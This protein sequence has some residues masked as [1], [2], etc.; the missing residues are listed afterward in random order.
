MSAS[1]NKGNPPESRITARALI[2]G[3]VVAIVFAAVT[4]Y[5]ENRKYL[6]ITATQIAVL[7]YMFLILTVLLINPLCRLLRI[8]RQFTMTEFLIIFIMGSVSAGI[9]T[10]G[11]ASQLMPATG[12]LFNRNWNNDQTEWNRYIEPVVNEAYFLSVPGIQDAAKAYNG[13]LEKFK[14]AQ[15]IYEA[16]L[17][18]KRADEAVDAARKEAEAADAAT[19]GTESERE[20]QRIRARDILNAARAVQGGARKTWEEMGKIDP[21]LPSRDE[22]LSAYPALI[23]ERDAA[24]KAKKE[25]LRVLEDAAAEKVDLFRRG[26]PE[27]KRAYPGF[28]PIVGD[29]WKTYWSRFQ[30][31]VHGRAAYRTLRGACEDLAAVMTP[32]AVP[33]D[34]TARVDE[35]IRLA[36]ERLKKVDMTADLEK[37]KKKLDDAWEAQKNDLLKV[38]AAVKDMN[39]KRRQAAAEDFDRLDKEIQKLRNKERGLKGRIEAF[40][41]R[42]EQVHFEIRAVSQVT[43][44]IEGLG[45]TAARLKDPNAD[46]ASLREGIGK[47]MAGFPA[48]DASLRRYLVSDVPWQHWARLML[49][50]GFLIVLTYVVLMAFNVLIF[51]QWAK[52]EKLIY[53]LAELPEMLAG[54][55]SAESGRMP[56]LFRTGFFWAGF[57]IAGATLGWN[58]LCYSKVIPGLQPFD[59][60]NEWDPY[61][62]NGPL[63][64]LY[65]TAKSHIFFTMI[66]LAFLVP[67]KISFSLWFFSILYMVQL[68]IIVWTGYGVNEES[69]PYE[70]MCTL[71]FRTAEGG[72]ALMVFA[73]AVLWKCR[74]YIL[75]FFTPS[76]VRELERDEQRELRTSSFLFVFGSVALILTLWRGMG[77]NPCYTVFSYFII[78]MITI[79]MIRAVAEGGILGFQAWVSPFHFIRTLF[80]M[81]KTWTAPPLFAPLLVYFSM[82]FLDIKTFI[83]PAMANSIKIR[84]DLRMKRGRFHLAVFLGIGAALVAAVA[85]HL[86]MSYDKGADAMNSWFYSAYPQDL[87]GQIAYMTK[88]QPVDPTANRWWLGA[89]ALFMGA[90]LYLRQFFFWLPHP[91]GLIMLVNPIMK[92]YWFSIL[93]GWLAKTL[94]TKYGRKESH[95]KAKRLFIGL[96]VGELFIVLLALIVSVALNVKIPID[97]NR[98]QQP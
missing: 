16:A 91:I 66:G 5:C 8:V 22:V 13:A 14:E 27:N 81:D 57:I 51:R 42:R 3:V 4:V 25:A 75:C 23:R 94:V 74:K 30:R 34:V 58:L 85:T 45:A 36:V 41:K 73:V 56:E 62:V 9:S 2:L 11:L 84:D 53:P 24:M 92:T 71:N 52:N 55:G 77:A 33:A 31:L 82:L 7:P 93:V 86:M 69:F 35:A 48:F 76:S 1:H 38:Q 64:G 21:G 32:G 61:I 80:G 95:N 46:A 67:A 10:F 26:L 83:A 47:L 63:S 17:R 50:W 72:G 20:M 6:Y 18:S 68:L 87:F 90:L 15:D 78:M 12:S 98:N 60:W 88:T 28:M 96:I 70:W 44:T 97:L 65:P 79:G 89:G 29:N 40:K 49:C 54:M 37:A 19:G 39:Q 59:L 43:A